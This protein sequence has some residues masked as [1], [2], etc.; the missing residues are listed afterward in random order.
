MMKQLTR[1]LC[2][3]LKVVMLRGTSDEGNETQKEGWNTRG[4]QREKEKTREKLRGR[5]GLWVIC[6]SYSQGK[7]SSQKIKYE[8]SLEG[9]TSVKNV[10]GRQLRN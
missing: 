4:K 1:D 8:I 3:H 7:I 9:R 2:K 10:L 6:S 5:I